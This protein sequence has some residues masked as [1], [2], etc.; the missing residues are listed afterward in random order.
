MKEKE[1][2]KLRARIEYL[3]RANSWYFF[4]LERLTSFGD[5]HKD[6]QQFREAKYLFANAEKYL[7]QLIGFKTLAFFQVDEQT[8]QFVLNDCHP[9]SDREKIQTVTDQQIENGSFAWALKKNRPLIVEGE[10][11]NDHF[12]FHALATKSRVRGMFAGWLKKKAHKIPV[13][14]LNLISVILSFTAYA[15]E[16]GMLYKIVSRQNLNLEEMVAKRTL[17]LETQ[18]H[19]LKKEI[20]ERKKVVEELNR[21]NQELQDFASIAS[22]D[23]QEPLRKVMIF[24]DR[25]KDKFSNKLDETGVSYLQRM[26]SASA[27]MQKLIDELLSF[28][29]VSTKAKP[30]ESTDLNKVLDEVLTDLEGRITKSNAKIELGGLPTIDADPVQMQQLFQNLVGNALKFKREGVPPVVSIGGHV[31][32]GEICEIRVQ[33]N[34]IGLDEKYVDRIFKPFERL[35]GRSEFEGTGMGLAICQKIVKRHNGSIK[36]KSGADSGSTFII[37]LPSR[38][39]KSS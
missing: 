34:G 3:E 9:E 4:A 2:D 15:L 33:D 1:I 37:Y 13:E 25:L 21:S 28:S 27:R 14:Q 18:A 30:F 23:L 36:V 19:E 38:Q 8:N 35:H 17:K 12:I 6:V 26:T 20:R 10:S 24:G 5:L 39:V 7:R 31:N 32:G 16:S 11:P 22:H 29:R